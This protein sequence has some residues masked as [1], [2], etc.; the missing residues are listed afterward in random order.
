[1]E[2]EFDTSSVPTIFSDIC[3]ARLFPPRTAA[4]V[5]SACALRTVRGLIRDKNKQFKQRILVNKRSISYMI[6]PSTTPNGFSSAAK[7]IVA[8]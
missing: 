1:M 4:V 7:P 3:E 6:P 8:I 5:Q 2:N